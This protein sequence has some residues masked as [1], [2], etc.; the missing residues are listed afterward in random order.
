LISY[1]VVVP[2]NNGNNHANGDNHAN[3]YST[4][5]SFERYAVVRRDHHRAG[6]AF[7]TFDG[8]TKI[9]RWPVGKRRRSSAFPGIARGIGIVLLACTAIYSIP[10]TAVLGAI[11]LTGYL[12][13]AA[14]TSAQERGRSRSPSIAFGVLAWVG[15]F[16]RAPVTLDD[17][18]AALIR[19]A[20]RDRDHCQR[21]RPSHR[22]YARGDQET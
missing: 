13:A 4:R 3:G 15:L 21:H 17:S 19:K 20:R 7:L 5:A 9:I 22:R 18:P 1:G 12:G 10:Q 16:P 11:L 2:V 6:G 8:V 14:I